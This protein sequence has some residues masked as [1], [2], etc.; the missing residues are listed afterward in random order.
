[1]KKLMFL[2]ALVM[3]LIAQQSVATAKPARCFSTDDGYFACNFIATD[4]RGSFE[5]SARG[6]P[7]YSLIVEE[8]G[9]GSAYLNFGDG[10]IPINGM[11]VRQREDPACWNNPERNVKLCAW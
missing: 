9:F 11:F 7:T 2:N 10:G 8:P 1:M 5:V 4:K 6:K 3:G